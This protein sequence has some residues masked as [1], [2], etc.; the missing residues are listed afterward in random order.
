MPLLAERDERETGVVLRSSVPDHL[1][2]RV[3]DLIDDTQ[4]LD[5]G[6]VDEEEERPLHKAATFYLSDSVHEELDEFYA[7]MRLIHGSDAPGKSHIVDVAIGEVL[8]EMKDRSTRIAKMKRATRINDM[9]FRKQE[10]K[11]HMARK[12]RDTWVKK[13]RSSWNRKSSSE[14]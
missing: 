11:E 13:D 14:D 5:S 9:L 6:D 4:L 2:Q 12:K 10:A 1:S 8:K 3:Q 7:L